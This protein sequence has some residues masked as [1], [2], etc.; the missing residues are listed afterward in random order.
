MSHFSYARCSTLRLRACG[1]CGTRSRNSAKTPKSIRKLHRIN[2]ADN[3]LSGTPDRYKHCGVLSKYNSAS[4]LVL[5]YCDKKLLGNA[6]SVLQIPQRNF[7]FE[8]YNKYFSPDVAPIGF[9]QKVLENIHTATGL[10]WWASIALSTILLRGIV[11]IPLA[12]YSTSIMAKVEL[13]QPQIMKLSLE[14]RREVAVAVKKFAWDAK[15][16]Q[17]KY[18]S[19]MKKLVSDLYI[20]DN[21]HPAKSSLVLWFQIPMWVCMSFALRNMSGA[22]PAAASGVAAPVLCPDLAAEGMLWFPDLTVPDA[23][24]VL[25]VLLGVVNLLNIEMHT[26]TTKQ[27]TKFHKGV[28]FV[29]RVL[30][31]FMVPVGAVVPSCMCYYWVCSSLIGLGQNFLFKMPSV[32][33]LLRVPQTPSESQT[34]FQDMINAARTKYVL[35]EQGKEPKT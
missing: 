34:P 12:V 1:H 9:T 25:P 32:R 13:L 3:S 33:R 5:P 10:P 31:L 18:N 28:T 2:L 27:V 8:T 29:M 22:V 16:A 23:T 15:K 4:F 35:R 21:C 11:T 6:H 7:S 20:R 30:S 14:L 26:L 19:T 24:W 17:S